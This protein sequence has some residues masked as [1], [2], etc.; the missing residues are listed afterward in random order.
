M[1]LFKKYYHII[2]GIF[3]FIVYLLTIAPSVIQIDSGELA[4]VQTTL[5]IAHPSGYP[6]YTMIGYLFSLLPLPFTKIFQLNLLA[7]IYCSSAVSVFAFT[8][9]YTLDNW[10]SFAKQVKPETEKSKKKK[11]EKIAEE[12]VETFSE[13]SKI[14]SAI[15]GSLVLA[16]SRTFWFQSTS[17]EVY[18]LHV[19]LISII[20][21]FLLKAFIIS[22]KENKT[23]I[24][25]YFAVVLALG[26][27]N[28]MTTLLILP[29]VAYLYFLR[30]KL[31]KAS[32]KRIVL[33]I[34]IFIPVLVVIYAYLPISA[35]QKPT[36]NWGNPIDIERILR[37]VSGKQYQV[38]LFS[39]TEAAEKQLVY[40][41]KSLPGEFS[42]I[43]ILSVI[44]MIVSLF[45]ARRLFFFLLITFLSTVL[46]SINYDIND[47][48]AYFLLA[49][50]VLAFFAALSA[51]NIL[52]QKNISQKIS[53]LILTV[54]LIILFYLNFG[55]VNQSAV[56]TFEDY[57][58][59]LIGS[60]P[61]NSIILSYQWDY[62]LSAT[63]YY[64]FVENY[65][66]DVTIIDKELLRRTWY[67]DQL[68]NYDPGLLKNLNP[69]IER[70]RAALRPFERDEKFD[71]NL[72]ES[73]FR[74]IMTG[75]V[76]EN[77]EQRDIYIAPELFENE[78]QK[79]EFILPEGYSLVPDLFLLKVVQNKDYIPAAE[80]DFAIRFPSNR[81]IYIDNIERIVGASL[82]RRAFYEM[83]FGMNDKAKIYVMKIINEFPNYKVPPVL[84]KLLQ[85]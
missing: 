42:F 22:E 5:G 48:D 81:N 57:T 75:I 79:G 65:R 76:A 24:W 37:H 49:Y 23:K 74:K 73:L 50:F 44:G 25:F 36:L 80:P 43:L 60:V 27:T 68:D 26:F 20:I 71:A 29:G 82:T 17:V 70:F 78:M 58:K 67:Y 83:N 34:G 31:S 39:S 4:A 51:F 32:V 63:Y 85:N 64:Q 56:Y 10:T 28:H 41:F 14:I 59:E 11:K 72:L 38:W 52:N 84:M 54:F 2:T 46:Y 8:I 55:K 12:N 53:S 6:L 19:L 18:S 9:K 45:K 3:V 33:M 35:A 77:I 69:N 61:E 62:W 16:F 21:L 40:F 15:F 13:P 30:Y 7:A 47:I 66:R 1:N